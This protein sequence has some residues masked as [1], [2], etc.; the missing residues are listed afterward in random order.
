MRSCNRARVQ[1]GEQ[2]TKY[3]W[4]PNQA[5]LGQNLPLTFCDLVTLRNFLGSQNPVSFSLKNV[6]RLR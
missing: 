5:I 6:M 4:S 3:M 2:A 1:D